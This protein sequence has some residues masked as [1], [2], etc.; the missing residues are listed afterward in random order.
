MEWF[1]MDG[2]KRLPASRKYL[3]RLCEFGC[4]GRRCFQ[5]KIDFIMLSASTMI[6]SKQPGAIFVTIH[7][8]LY[9]IAKSRTREVMT[10]AAMKV[11][12]SRQNRDARQHTSSISLFFT[13]QRLILNR[14]LAFFSTRAVVTV[15]CLYLAKLLS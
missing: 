14:T 10:L 2:Q 7:D 1:K 12:V 6:K 15:Q 5:I 8:V 9:E 11:E 4:L 13:V 3:G